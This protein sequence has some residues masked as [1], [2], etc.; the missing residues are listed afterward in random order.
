LK[1]ETI[2]GL[3]MLVVAALNKEDSD[4]AV[5]CSTSTQIGDVFDGG[6]FFSRSGVETKPL[7][8]SRAEAEFEAI[9]NLDGVAESKRVSVIGTAHNS[10]LAVYQ[11]KYEVANR[12]IAGDQEAISALAPEAAERGEKPEEL[13]ALVKLLGDQWRAAGLAIDTA[14]QK[15]KKTIQGLQTV[16]E[17]DAYDASSGWPI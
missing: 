16:E 8:R 13:A 9:A 5:V 10:K 4:G 14:Y 3:S 12:A 6:V 2:N 11:V 15:H 17:I 1:E 7:P